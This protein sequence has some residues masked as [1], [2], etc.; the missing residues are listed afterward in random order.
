MV[1]FFLFFVSFPSHQNSHFLWSNKAEITPQPPHVMKNPIT[2]Q[3]TKIKAG[4][5]PSEASTTATIM[6]MI[7]ITVKSKV[8]IMIEKV[9]FPPHGLPKHCTVS[10]FFTKSGSALPKTCGNKNEIFF[11]LEVQY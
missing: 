6:I 5:C 3:A 9:N 10:C 2:L 8:L 4:C 11:P 1:L 7:M